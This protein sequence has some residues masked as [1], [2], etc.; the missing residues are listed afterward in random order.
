MHYDR[1]PS[2]SVKTTYPQ[3]VGSCFCE[4]L[5]LWLKRTTPPPSWQEMADALR[6]PVIGRVDIAIKV[7]AKAQEQKQA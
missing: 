1:N 4:M 5:S 7:E 2:Q 3:D 6:S